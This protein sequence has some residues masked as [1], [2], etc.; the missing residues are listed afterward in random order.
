MKRRVLLILFVAVLIGGTSFT[1][2]QRYN[3]RAGVPDW[4]PDREFA[5]DVFTFVRI[6]YDSYGGGGRSRGRG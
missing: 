4:E 6:E 1:L 5:E 2:A 3:D